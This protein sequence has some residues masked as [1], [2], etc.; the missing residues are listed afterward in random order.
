MH[1]K[2]SMLMRTFVFAYRNEIDHSGHLHEFY[3]AC[4]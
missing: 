2:T 4:H 3:D 1:R